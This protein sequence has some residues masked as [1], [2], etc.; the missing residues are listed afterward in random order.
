[1][2]REG[3]RGKERTVIV[4][5]SSSYYR[6]IDIELRTPRT[7]DTDKRKPIEEGGREDHIENWRR[8]RPK[9]G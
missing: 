6:S 5:F 4:F 2:Q 8:S 7:K 1:M 3:E 9:G